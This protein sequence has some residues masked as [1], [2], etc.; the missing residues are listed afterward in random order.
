MSKI[1]PFI[2]IVNTDVWI[3]FSRLI[4]FCLLYSLQVS[5][6]FLVLISDFCWAG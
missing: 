2:F 3:Y 6:S 5:F 1:N 4:F